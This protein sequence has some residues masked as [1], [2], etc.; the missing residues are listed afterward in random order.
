MVVSTNPLKRIIDKIKNMIRDI[1][2]DSPYSEGVSG[3][4]RMNVNGALRDSSQS[5]DMV[6]RWFNK[7]DGHTVDIV[8][9]GPSEGPNGVFIMTADGQ[10]ISMEVFANDYIQ[11][12]IDEQTGEYIVPNIDA[13]VTPRVD[14][15]T[16]QDPTIVASQPP[17]EFPTTPTAGV[18]LD[19]LVAKAPPLP[20][21]SESHQP[22]LS[23]NYAIIDKALSKIEGD[24]EYDVAVQWEYPE[25]EI[26][27]LHEVM[28]ISY[29]EIADYFYSRWLAKKGDKI[30]RDALLKWI[31]KS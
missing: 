27:L 21:A 28:D 31:T 14:V 10:P 18:L 3:G 22:V 15:G 17:L 26:T 1:N 13:D 11:C 7:N 12:P 9:G 5:P 19:G 16:L 30:L 25:K 23:P 8:D 6:G 29:E 2:T 24:P 4:N 20:T